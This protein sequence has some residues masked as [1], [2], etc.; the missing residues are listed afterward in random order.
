MIDFLLILVTLLLPI[1]PGANAT[2]QL[3][4]LDWTGGLTVA[5][6]DQL[7]FGA[8]FLSM[9]APDQRKAVGKGKNLRLRPPEYFANKKIYDAKWKAAN[10]GKM[11]GYFKK[12]RLAHLEKRKAKESKY[13]KAHRQKYTELQRAWRESHPNYY[14]DMMRRKR[15][16]D[17]IGHAD[18]KRKYRQA[19]KEAVRQYEQNYRRTHPHKFVAAAAK[20]RAIK[21]SVTV[22]EA[23]IEEF[24]TNA[25][26]KRFVR[27]FYCRAKIKGSDLH[28]DHV[29]SLSKGG[30]HELSNIAISCQWCNLSKHNRSLL[31]WKPGGQLFLI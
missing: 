1:D 31:E 7:P 20:R 4:R 21:A 5:A 9:N 18:Y 24:L 13:R 10:P 19:N 26:S 2:Q 3:S 17:P 25:R 11:R 8:G 30:P 29:V 28:A 15:A 14:R 22:N 23:G 6:T 12:Y 16:A 27:C